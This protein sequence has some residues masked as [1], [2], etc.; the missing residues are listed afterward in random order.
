MSFGS[1]CGAR[2]VAIL[3]LGIGTPSISHST[4]WPPAHVQHIVGHVGRGHIIGDHR[5]AI[6]TVAPGVW[7]I[8]SRLTRVVGVTEST[9][10]MSW[11]PRHN[12]VV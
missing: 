6:G 4:W 2:F 11:C 12:K 3:V 8:S 5:K 1:I 10:A 9:F 7:A